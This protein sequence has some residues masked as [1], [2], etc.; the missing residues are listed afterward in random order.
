MNLSKRIEYEHVQTKSQYSTDQRREDDI[1][2]GFIRV[3]LQYCVRWG[4]S[5]RPSRL[6]R[7][8]SNKASNAR[9]PS[10]PAAQLGVR[11]SRRQAQSVGKKTDD[12]LFIISDEDAND[13]IDLIEDSSGN[14][15]DS[16]CRSALVDRPVRLEEAVIGGKMKAQSERGRDSDAESCSSLDSIA[17]GP[18][19]MVQDPV[20]S[21]S[22]GLCWTCQR[23]YRGI[24]IRDASLDS[25]TD[26]DPTSLS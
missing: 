2:G 9:T 1:T 19:F 17:S 21:R 25:L 16:E 5:M 12:S 24:S 22:S 4:S 7:S 23:R 3:N 26:N 13:P 11:K 10:D 20:L 14:S 18:S 8:S 15:S 6:C